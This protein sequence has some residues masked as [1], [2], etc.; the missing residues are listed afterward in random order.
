MNLHY[1][2]KIPKDRVAVLIGEKGSTKK[3]LEKLFQL[4]ATID[5]EEGDVFLDGEDSLLLHTAQT[6]VKAIGRGL[7]PD[8]AFTLANEDYVLE[9]M[10]IT[11]FVGNAKNSIFRV[12]SR[13]IGSEGRTRE[14]I[15]ELT[16][17]HISIYGKTVAIVGQYEWVA[18]ARKAIES[19]LAGQRHAT[20]YAWLEKHAQDLQKS[21]Y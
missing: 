6:V 11:D 9:T 1:E 12:R 20:V 13:I 2:L 16:D 18:L 19:L 4:T 3:K 15:E 17:T 5:S 21:F 8:V 10:D 14:Y 7:N